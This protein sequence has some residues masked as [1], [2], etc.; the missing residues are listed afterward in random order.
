MFLVAALFF[1]LAL[2]LVGITTIPI[3]L[4]LLVVCAVVFRKSWVFFLAF[5]LGFILDLLLLRPP[6]QTGLFLILFISIVF[7]YER[8]FET[9]TKTFVFISTFLGSLIY[10]WLFGYNQ[11]L[12]Q[13][14]VNSLLAVLF[15]RFVI[16]NLFRDLVPRS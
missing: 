13:A 9:R 8:K 14:L 3:L 15:F 11:V 5:I 7:L 2:A 16:P 4:S 6:G 1:L 12:M 10:L